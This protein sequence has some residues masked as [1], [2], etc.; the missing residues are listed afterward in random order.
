MDEYLTLPQV[1]KRLGLKDPAGLR[2]AAT[3]RR[4]KIAPTMAPATSR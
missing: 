4:W 3:S 2:Y 1:T